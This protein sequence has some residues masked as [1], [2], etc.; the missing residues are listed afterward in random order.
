MVRHRVLFV[1]A[2]NI[3]RSP[4]AE[5]IFRHLASEAGRGHEF[6][7][8]SAGIG[9]WHQGEPPDRR[10]IAVAADH[11]IDISA[12]RARRIEPSDF[13]RFD[14]I[15]AMDQ[16]NLKNLR[17][18]APADALGKLHL[19]NTLA[20]GSSKDIPDPYYGE[21]KDFEAVYTMLLAGCSELLPKDGN[22]LRGS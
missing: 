8:D 21:R 22:V 20:L 10:S 12:Q 3:C 9:G 18:T 4:L 5:G 1:C 14:L 11:G 13:S 7:I 6:E 16:D 17:K 19:F 2:G 15:L